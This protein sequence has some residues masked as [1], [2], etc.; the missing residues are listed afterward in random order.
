MT[1]CHKK[2]RRHINIYIYIYI[3]K[4]T[5]GDLGPHECSISLPPLLNHSLTQLFWVSERRPGNRSYMGIIPV[6]NCTSMLGFNFGHF[7]VLS[8]C[9]EKNDTITHPHSQL[10]CWELQAPAKDICLNS[11]IHCVS[12]MTLMLHTAHYNFD[13][14]QLILIIFGK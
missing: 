14:D 6:P 8:K 1:S 9:T 10:M 3:S 13:T 12:K 2:E 5:S 4:V 11:I 7:V